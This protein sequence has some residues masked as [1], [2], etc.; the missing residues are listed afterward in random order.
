MPRYN[1]MF[2]GDKSSTF[3]RSFL[4]S[5]TLNMVIA[6]PSSETPVIVTTQN[7]VIF[8]KTLNFTYVQLLFYEKMLLW[9][10]FY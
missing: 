4:P 1:A 3:Y 9:K 7:G 8:Q 2:I 5:I 10:K 6:G